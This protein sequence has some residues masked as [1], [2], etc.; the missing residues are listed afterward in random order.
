MASMRWRVHRRL[1]AST[2][3]LR[4]GASRGSHIMRA[5]GRNHHTGRSDGVTPVKV[6]RRFFVGFAERITHFDWVTTT[7]VVMFDM[8]VLLMA[9]YHAGGQCEGQFWA[10]AGQHVSAQLNVWVRLVLTQRSKVLL[11]VSSR[12]QIA[13]KRVNGA[14][15]KRV[16]G[17]GL[18]GQEL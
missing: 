15:H 16:V 8:R 5:S 11:D 12:G 7:W 1:H 4:R 13:G 9:T 3:L 10:G 6:R 18:G 2:C 14:E 17:C